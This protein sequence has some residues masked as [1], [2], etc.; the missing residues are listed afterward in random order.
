MAENSE[1]YRVRLTPNISDTNLVNYGAVQQRQDATSS[2]AT[3]SLSL[4]SRHFMALRFLLRLLSLWCPRSASC[5]ESIVYPILVNLILLSLLLL[6]GY[7]FAVYIG[8]LSG[9][10]DPFR[11]QTY[12]YTRLPLQILALGAYGRHITAL[13]YFR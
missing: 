10:G 7:F 9:H 3:T 4:K 12:A 13:V 11:E 2:S 8:V 6:I 1:D 5:L